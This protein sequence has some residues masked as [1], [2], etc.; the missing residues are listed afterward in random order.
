MKYPL[1]I[2]EWDD[3]ETFI[4]WE[5]LPKELHVARV[6]T[7]GFLAMES[8]KH[9]LLI[10]SYEPEGKETNDRMQIPKGMIISRREINADA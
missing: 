4:G 8:E 6:I 1:V 9:I 5:E 2:V 3:A 7:V 10:G